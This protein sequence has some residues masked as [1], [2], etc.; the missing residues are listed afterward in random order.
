[1][2]ALA[3]IVKSGV[4]HINLD[5]IGDGPDFE[6]LKCKIDKYNLIPFVSLLGNQSRILSQIERLRFLNSSMHCDWVLHT[7]VYYRLIY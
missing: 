2:A 1:M 7:D 5:F 3:D 6:D 4:S